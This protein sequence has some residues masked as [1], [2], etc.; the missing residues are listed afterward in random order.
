MF[1]LATRRPLWADEFLLFNN[2]RELKPLEIFGILKYSQGFP[3]LYLFIIRNFSFL[4]QFDV[5]SLRILPFIFMLSSFA[6]WLNIFK[7]EEKEEFG[8]LLF[9][10]S[11]SGSTL[12]SYYAAEFKQ[13]SAELF[14]A[15]VFT[16]FIIKQRGLLK[17]ENLNL[18]LALSYVLLPGLVLFSYTSY[19]FILLPA[20]NLLLTNRK[21]KSSFIYL[22][23]Y[24]VSTLIFVFSSYNYDIRYTITNP[25]LTGYWKAYF[26]STDSFYKFIGT[27]WEGLRR[28]YVRWFWEGKPFTHIMTLFMPFATFFT[29][30]S[31][32]KRFKEDD[33][34]IVSLSTI[35]VFLLTSLFISGI[36]KIL[37]FT[38]ARVTLY[39]APFIFY[40]II[41]SINMFRNKLF[42]LYVILNSVFILT[43]ITT[44]ILIL[45]GYIKKF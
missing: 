33:R 15:G 17:N 13:Y 34:L 6:I 28:I 22:V 42:V 8:Y 23:I 9:I 10:L 40:A 21:N 26:I 24:L 36:L 19:F 18:P 14:A 16:H 41:E 27:F 37:P 7:K 1:H 29:F 44:S 11:W 35:L 38:A 43:V 25:G 32:F 39:L 12:M 20:Y 4:F 30:Y 2:F 31:A 45:S 5:L 3:R